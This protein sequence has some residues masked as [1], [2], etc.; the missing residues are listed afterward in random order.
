MMQPVFSSEHRNL[1]LYQ[2]PRL[3]PH[4][5]QLSAKLPGSAL[6]SR[7]SDSQPF[8]HS[9][10]G[11]FDRNPLAII[12][13]PHHQLR[14][15]RLSRE[16]GADMATH[17]KE[18]PVFLLGASTNADTHHMPVLPV[19][20]VIVWELDDVNFTLAAIGSRNCFVFLPDGDCYVQ[21]AQ[22]LTRR[23]YT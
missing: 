10:P 20:V 22:K 4:Y 16:S 3:T 11:N 6:S 12:P 15:I 14:V 7:Y 9:Y 21:I 5:R 1:R 23:P 19:K 2:R 18:D 13:N 17:K 8:R